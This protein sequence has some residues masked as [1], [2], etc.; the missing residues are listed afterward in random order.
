MRLFKVLF[1]IDCLQLKFTTESN[2]LASLLE[3][4]LFANE[5]PVGKTGFGRIMEGTG[6]GCEVMMT[7]SQSAEKQNLFQNCYHFRSHKIN[8]GKLLLPGTKN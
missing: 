4:E 3:Q 2:E 6:V 8:N 7:K 1:I 5:H